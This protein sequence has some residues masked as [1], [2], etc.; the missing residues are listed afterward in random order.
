MA[1]LVGSQGS[2]TVPP[3]AGGQ[4]GL[5]HQFRITFSR[6]ARV[7][8]AF[9]DTG[10]AKI[11]RGGMFSYRGTLFAYF[12]ADNTLDLG[13]AASASQGLID[14]GATGAADF[15]LVLKTGK[16]YSFTGLYDV[17]SCDTEKVGMA[18]VTMSVR[19]SSAV[20][21]TG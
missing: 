6:P 1:F 7:V 8:N 3:A 15:V 13:E 5:I 18:A 10:T 17:L 4:T 14:E 2:V 9:A 11:K 20:V 19:G 21:P 12:D 16:Q